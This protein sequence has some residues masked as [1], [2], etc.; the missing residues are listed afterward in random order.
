[1]ASISDDAMISLFCSLKILQQAAI[2]L[3]IPFYLQSAATTMIDL[4]QAG[5]AQS[6][7]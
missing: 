6:D 1:M 4:I 5:E 2:F 7:R 3:L